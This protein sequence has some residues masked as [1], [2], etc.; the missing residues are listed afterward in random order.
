[1]FF[2]IR[3]IFEFF[4]KRGLIIGPKQLYLTERFEKN[5]R[6]LKLNIFASL[7]FFVFLG[8]SFANSPE[9][10]GIALSG[11]GLPI[12]EDFVPDSIGIISISLSD[13]ENVYNYNFFIQNSKIDTF[14]I[15]SSAGNYKV[16]S[17]YY[18]S[19]G[20]IRVLPAFLSLIPPLLA[21][22]L[23]FLIREVIVSL[24]A[25]VYAGV[26]IMSG[27]D[28]FIA[29]LRTIDYYIINSLVDKS[30]I[31]IIVFSMMIGGAVGIISANGGMRGLA[32]LIIRFAKNRRS[33][34]ISSW[35]LGLFIFFDDYANTLIVG[36]MMRPITDRLKISR[37]KLSYI[38]DSTSAP[39]ASVVI[40]S[41]W[42]G[43]ELGLIGDSLALIGSTESAYSVFLQSIPFRFYPI[44]ALF[45]VFLTSFTQR[46]F[47]AMYKAEERAIKKGELTKNNIDPTKDLTETAVIN[48]KVIDARWING[49]VPIIVL[50]AG[51]IL[52]LMYTGVE[53][54]TKKGTQNYHI[55]DIIF[56]SDSNLALL[57]GSFLSCI[58]AI[59]MTI[60]Q[61]LLNVK[62]AL[63]SWFR[64]V[65]SMLYAMLILT[66]AWTI[67]LVA[68][69][70]K[71]ADYLITSLNNVVDPR[72]L[73]VF[74][75]II[76]AITSFATGTSWGSMAIVM[77]IALPLAYSIGSNY[78][79]SHENLSVVIYGVVSSVLAGSVFG[80]HC[81]PIA[82]TTIL[83]SMASS[84]DHI[85]HVRTQMPYAIIVGLF[86]MLLGD[87]PTAFGVNPF[88]SL[89]TI[90]AGLILFLF[91]IGKK[92]PSDS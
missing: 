19:G 3:K 50:I 84:C 67:G 53:A 58:T 47:G 62:D 28:P 43:Y 59:I 90:L 40:I 7:C 78:G 63:D 61:K 6:F 60:S 79:L 29:F 24:F 38:V 80:D 27:Y 41:T 32:N 54:L 82:D 52:G 92:L 77:P 46:D 34:T 9:L 68:F 56:N 26:F 44:A 23:A 16:E 89:L 64:G 87:I 21:I 91:L 69:E 85:E 2:K 75:F 51:V 86:C 10:P 73:P 57:W 33:G 25:G 39:V 72:F 31:S 76:C 18:M 83:S 81:S 5:E 22:I 71:T 14:L 45:F 8:H 30:H 70:I 12:K 13:E 49:A 65:R 66:L 36:N 11:V 74:V 55:T 35:F 1:M 17:N 42:I 37:E 15:I 4:L 20:A 88:L 48:E